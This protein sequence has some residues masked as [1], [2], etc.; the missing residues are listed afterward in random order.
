MQRHYKFF[1]DCLRQVNQAV[2]RRLNKLAVRYGRALS[3]RAGE[4]QALLAAPIEE[5]VAVERDVFLFQM[6][7]LLRDTDLRGLWP[8]HH[9]GLRELPGY[10]PTLCVDLYQKKTGEPVLIPVPPAAADVCRVADRGFWCGRASPHSPVRRRRK[11]KSARRCS[12]GRKL[13]EAGNTYH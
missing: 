13:F 12:T 9:V 5:E 6:F 7:L 2:P 10:G 4:V 8:P 3:L 1:R 11:I